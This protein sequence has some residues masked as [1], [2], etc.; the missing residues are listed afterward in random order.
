MQS[1]IKYF[2]I[3]MV[4]VLSILPMS[5]SIIC[6]TISILNGIFLYTVCTT[7]IL[8]ILR[9]SLTNSEL[10]FNNK[11][12]FNKLSIENKV[13]QEIKEIIRTLSLS[14]HVNLPNIYIKKRQGNLPQIAIECVTHPNYT[15]IISE[16]L[17]N[18]YKQGISK[19][20]LSL[21][22]SHELG[23]FFHRDHFWAGGIMLAQGTY[24]IQSIVTLVCVLTLPPI[25][26]LTIVLGLSIGFGLQS[27]FSKIHSR[28]CEYTADSFAV[29]LYQD[30]AE[31]KCLFEHIAQAYQY[32]GMAMHQNHFAE[33][34]LYSD[35]QVAP[36]LEWKHYLTLQPTL[37]EKQTETLFSLKKNLLQYYPFNIKQDTLNYAQYLLTW[38]NSYPTS[39]ERKIRLK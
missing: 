15:I 26:A 39:E 27:L 25:V 8:G 19:A 12:Y 29:I 4:C 16:D 7:G 33:Y 2:A 6:G 21:L 34:K 31:M 30:S 18:R 36:L 38:F 11:K 10:D 13:H 37:D 20:Q 22:I 32:W 5:A 35:F 17:I 28:F 1:Y 23:H 24:L 3:A 14:A 9:K